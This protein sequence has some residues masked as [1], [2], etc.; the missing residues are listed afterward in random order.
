MYQTSVGNINTGIA[1]HAEV[2]RIKKVAQEVKR[3]GI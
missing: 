2:M 1:L 3:S